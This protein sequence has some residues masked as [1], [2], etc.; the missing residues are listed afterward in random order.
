MKT[1]TTISHLIFLVSFGML[2]ATMLNSQELPEEKQEIIK[3]FEAQLEEARMIEVAPDIQPVIPAKKKYGYNVTILPLDIKYPEPVIKPIAADADLPFEN[4]TFFTRLGYGNVKNPSADLSFYKTDQYQFDRYLNVSYHGF[5]NTAKIQNQ[6]LNDAAAVAGI[7]YKIKE[8]WQINAGVNGAYKQSPLYFVYADPVVNTERNIFR[9]GF[10]AEIL[11]ETINEDD[12]DFSLATT[13]SVVNVSNPDANEGMFEVQTQVSKNRGNW[14][15]TFPLQF[16]GVLQSNISDL[17]ALRFFP[18]LKYSRSSWHLTA[19]AAI[20]YDAQEKTV[21]WP[22]INFDYALS[23]K[24]LHIFA[25]SK[26]RV[27]AN[28]LHRLSAENPWLNPA[29]SKL[30]NFLGKEIFGGVRGEGKILGYEIAAGYVNG[31]NWDQFNNIAS[32]I[33]ASPF[34][35]QL[36]AAFLRSSVDFA[37]SNRVVISG[38]L[39]KNF[40]HKNGAAHLYGLHTFECKAQ[41]QFKFWNG[42][43]KLTPELFVTDRSW[44]RI[45]EDFSG[46]LVDVRL[47]NRVELNTTLDI[48]FSNK[49]G[50]YVKGGNLLN[51]RYEQWFG[52][53]ILGIHGQGGILLKL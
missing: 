47:N 35:T 4:H 50:I 2:N 52:Y 8:N 51:N 34:F 19:G 30:T 6:K 14:K 41:A 42:K 27:E 45:A 10:K 53:P 33:N 26:L 12:L 25:G 22:Q 3:T 31:R 18:E 39:T 44:T 7:R 17:Y 20:Y 21:P 48:W 24:S 15:L 49:L 23:G 36:K 46:S 29:L 43:V 1:K 9:A 38:I 32:Q 13:Y 16:T 37:V 40:F 11:H 28:N 5:D